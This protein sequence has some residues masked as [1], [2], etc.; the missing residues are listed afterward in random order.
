MKAKEYVDALVTLKFTQV[1]ISK[2]TGIS[3]PSL[4]KVVNGM[5][6]GVRKARM[7]ALVAL[8][9]RV[10]RTQARKARIAA[11]L[12]GLVDLPEPDLPAPKPTVLFIRDDGTVTPDERKSATL[13]DTNISL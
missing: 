11:G 13:H 10:M 5:S 4:S 9:K 6:K 2:I 7:V 8:Y 1:K 12:V 3:Q